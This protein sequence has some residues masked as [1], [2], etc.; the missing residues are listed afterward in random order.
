[1]D[2]IVINLGDFLKNAGIVGLNY[3]LE[4][5]ICAEKDKD[6]GYTPDRQAIWLSRDFALNCDW[7]D[8]YFKAFTKYY[9]DYSVY[10]AVIDEIN[11]ILAVIENDNFKLKDM[12][13]KLKFASV[14]DKLGVT[15]PYENL[16]VQKLKDTMDVQ[17]VKRK[18]E[19]LLHFLK[20]PIC[21]ETFVMKSALY[22]YINRFWD[23]KCFLLRANAAKNMREVFETDFAVPLREYIKKSHDKEKDK[24]KFL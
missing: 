24:R 2:R 23:G 7:T 4:D 21:E 13:D 9:R 3:I 6:Y 8:I 14:K 20:Q 5:V 18:L 12:K 16:Q 1:M 15:H 17:E 11:S 10:Q 22:N 19:E